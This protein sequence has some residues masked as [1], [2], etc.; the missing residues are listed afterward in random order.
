MQLPSLKTELLALQ[1]STLLSW[2]R[3][4]LLRRLEQPFSPDS[5]H[6]DSNISPQLSSIF[7]S[8][9][10]TLTPVNPVSGYGEARFPAQSSTSPTPTGSATTG[11][12][13]EQIMRLDRPSTG[14]YS[15]F[16]GSR[17]TTALLVIVVFLI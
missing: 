2:T 9:V 14:T 5:G 7:D 15:R 8:E 1:I 11:W 6:R 4:S 12:N 10:V 16:L 17:V 3:Y 13:I